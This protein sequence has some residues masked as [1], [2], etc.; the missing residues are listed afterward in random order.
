[1][2]EIKMKNIKFKIISIFCA[3]L[4]LGFATNIVAMKKENYDYTAKSK[5]DLINEIT[6]KFEDILKKTNTRINVIK[7]EGGFIKEEYIKSLKEEFNTLYENY[8]DIT[9]KKN[10]KNK[11]LI[12]TISKTIT[13]IQ[14]NFN[15]IDHISEIKSVY[16]PFVRCL[17]PFKTIFKNYFESHKNEEILEEIIKI[18]NETFNKYDE[19]ETINKY[20]N[21]IFKIENIIEKIKDS[22]NKEKYE[23]YK[24]IKKKYEEYLEKHEQLYKYKIFKNKFNKKI[25][26][27]E[28]IFELTK[29]INQKTNK[30]IK[31]PLKNSSKT[32]K[33]K[34]TKEEII[35]EYFNKEFSSILN[36]MNKIIENLN[37]N[38]YCYNKENLKKQYIEK[39]KKFKKIQEEYNKK[40]NN[41]FKQIKINLDIKNEI[42]NN[43][44]QIED[45]IKT[46]GEKIILEVVKKQLNSQLKELKKLDV[47]LNEINKN[48]KLTLNNKKNE[49]NKSLNLTLDNKKKVIEIEEKNEYIKNNFNNLL[50]ENEN[51]FN[52]SC[53]ETAENISKIIDKLDQNLKN[54]NDQYL[55]AE[56]K[57]IITLQ[58]FK[59]KFEDIEN[60]LLNEEDNTQIE[61]N[62]KNLLK[63]YTYFLMKNKNKIDPNSKGVENNH[64]IINNITFLIF[65]N[66]NKKLLN[67]NDILMKSHFIDA[68]NEKVNEEETYAKGIQIKEN[69]IDL[70]N[71]YNNYLMEKYAK[72]KTNRIY[73]QNIWNIMLKIK[74]K[75]DKMNSKKNNL[76]NEYS[77]EYSRNKLFKLDF[78][79]NNKEDEKT[80]DKKEENLNN[81][82]IKDNNFYDY[83]KSFEDDFNYELDKEDEKTENEK[84]ENLNNNI[85]IKDNNFYDYIKNFE[86]DFNHELDKED[87]KTENEKEKNLNNINIKDNDFYDY[88]KNFEDDFNYELDKED[89]KTE[90]EKEENL[91]NNINNYLDKLFD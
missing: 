35:I 83:I 10:K 33:V 77:K 19:K 62:Y 7:K 24:K 18:L 71:D 45:L 14:N 12:N 74:T 21:E 60:Q 82:N 66:I 59:N 23:E 9:E 34:K 22:Y 85:N 53:A 38:L 88:I 78:F 61:K 81:I 27:I 30:V 58:H 37:S 87:E 13:N 47:D 55:N 57:N 40:L 29:I 73:K 51:V 42:S 86:D 31:K 20:L 16:S 56:I 64:I 11:D 63:Y 54:I 65:E 41:E 4:T 36:E 6:K 15:E 39:T 49:T 17:K 50:K 80:E 90:D 52:K 72:F 3:F 1:M 46:R 69:Y 89:E 26:N 44:K 8:K 28:Q 5:K 43:I 91:N 48:L 75:I 68:K 84:E 67:I 2:E 76:D 25:N 79:K 70:L 32:T